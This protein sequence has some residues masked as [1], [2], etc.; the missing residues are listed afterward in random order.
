[1]AVGQ[2]EGCPYAIEGVP[3]GMESARQVWLT[4]V[5]ENVSCAAGWF[6]VDLVVVDDAVAAVTVELGSP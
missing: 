5:G 4:S 2:H 1:M 6:A 3:A